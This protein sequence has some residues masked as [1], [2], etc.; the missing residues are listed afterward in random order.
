MYVTEVILIVDL[1]TIS[2]KI[3]VYCKT[4]TSAT[5]SYRSKNP[6]CFNSLRK[7][8]PCTAIFPTL[9][10]LLEPE[11]SYI[12]ANLY[13]QG[14]NPSSYKTS[15]VQKYSYK[16]ERKKTW[17]LPVSASLGIEK[18]SE[19][20]PI[21]LFKCKLLF[22]WLFRIIP[23]QPAFRLEWCFGFVLIPTQQSKTKVESS[24]QR[25]MKRNKSRKQ[26]GK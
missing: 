7:K 17:Q 11:L 18:E 5:C 6:L 24:K 10:P 8:R 25:R 12:D 21:S 15:L 4:E 9:P 2:H 13:P 26:A 3:L 14:F 19:L 22:R 20:C 16:V 1:Q 23:E